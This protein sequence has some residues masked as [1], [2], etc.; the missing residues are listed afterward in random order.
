[1]G[2]NAAVKYSLTPNDQFSI[3]EETGVI[4]PVAGAFKYEDT[5]FTVHVRDAEGE[6]EPLEVNVSTETP[7]KHT[8][9]I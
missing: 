3:H 1:L 5:H 6:G 9:N 8:L 7:G 4:Y 2:G